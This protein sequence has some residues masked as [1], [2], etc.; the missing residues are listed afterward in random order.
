MVK[1]TSITYNQDRHQLDRHGTGRIA[2]SNGQLTKS[3][4]TMKSLEIHGGQAGVTGCRFPG[5]RHHKAWTGPKRLDDGDNTRWTRGG[6]ERHTTRLSF[7]PKRDRFFLLLLL[8]NVDQNPGKTDDN[9]TASLDIEACRSLCWPSK[10]RNSWGGSIT[11][12][13]KNI[14]NTP[15]GKTESRISCCPPG[16]VLNL[17]LT[18]SGSSKQ[19][20]FDPCGGSIS[21]GVQVGSP[22]TDGVSSPSVSHPF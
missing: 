15:L 2:S 19:R 22:E 16:N 6:R 13:A 21:I 20:G 12:H 18:S 8:I 14:P 1:D 7:F 4:P 11:P 9:R 10:G 3:L 5:M 17:C